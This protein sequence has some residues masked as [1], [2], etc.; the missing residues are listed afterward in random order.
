VTA[1]SW[2]ARSARSAQLTKENDFSQKVRYW[3]NQAKN[4]VDFVW[5]ENINEPYPIEVKLNYPRRQSFPPGLKS[6]ISMYHPPKGFIIHLVDFSI[7]SS[8]KTEIYFI[9]PWAI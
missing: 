2:S 8:K 5:Q 7:S 6:F 3:R 4:E 1:T 9:P